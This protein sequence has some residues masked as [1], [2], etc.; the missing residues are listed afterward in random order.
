MFGRGIF[1]LI[2]LLVVANCRK[3]KDTGQL[4]QKHC[5]QCH[6]APEPNDLDMKSW[7]L[8][9]DSMGEYL[10]VPRQNPAGRQLNIPHAS[11]TPKRTISDSDWQRLRAYFI[12]GAHKE[13]KPKIEETATCSIPY[14]KTTI[15]L[16]TRFPVIS[17]ISWDA[18]CRCLR[19]ANAT[20]GTLYQADLNGAITRRVVVGYS[21]TGGARIGTTN[22][23]VAAKNLQ[24]N[25]EA[26]GILFTLKGDKV[27]ILRQDLIRP[28]HLAAIQEK[29]HSASIVVSEF[30]HS[31]GRLS[32]FSPQTF[33]RQVLSEMPGYL[34]SAQDP[35]GHIV[36]L[37][38]QADEAITLFAPHEKTLLRFSPAWG[39][40]SMAFVKEKE[41]S[42]PS[43]A[44]THGDNGD[45]PGMPYKPMHGVRVYADIHEGA[46]PTFFYPMPG[47][48]KVVAADFNKDGS[49]DLAAIAYFTGFGKTESP[50]FR[51]L[52]HKG[53]TYAP[54]QIADAEKG[55]WIT[56]DAR[57]V[58]GDGKSDIALGGAYAPNFRFESDIGKKAEDFPTILLLTT[59]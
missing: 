53:G 30:G 59:K 24:P 47:A 39:S 21:V 43:I 33:E 14:R 10:G 16:K 48:Y 19:F 34:Y 28:V 6:Q 20:D 17:W 35:Q 15:Q 40:T 32:K 13:T 27:K 12:E 23:Y 22:Y 29:N 3:K 25:D 11:N 37:R 9:L 54:C 5:S 52:L 38:A 55:R 56:M 57:D 50:H 8:V 26:N 18:E 1:F 42:N 58:D 44:T 51:L 49:E 41:K 36:A 7:G 2:T 4:A 46:K 45:L 31:R